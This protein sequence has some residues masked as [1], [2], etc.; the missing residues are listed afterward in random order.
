[1]DICRPQPQALSRRQGLKL[2]KV[3]SEKAAQDE[4]RVLS[5]FFLIR[6]GSNAVKARSCL[7][8]EPCLRVSQSD[9]PEC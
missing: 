9:N 6:N 3:A 2:G 5:F 8:G 1:M 7:R 4:G